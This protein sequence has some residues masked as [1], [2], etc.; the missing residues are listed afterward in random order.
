MEIKDVFNNKK[1]LIWGYGRE[2]KSSE[3]FIRTHCDVRALH[4][5]EGDISGI[6]EDEW[7]IILK[8]PGI[9]MLE[10]RPKYTSQTRLFLNRYGHQTVGITG[11]KGKSTTSSLMYEAIKAC[12]RDAI[13]LG[14]IGKPC[15]DYIDDIKCDTIVV[16]ELSAHQL[17]HIEEAPAVAIFLNLYP[18]HLDYYGTVDK[19]FEAKAN[20]TTHQKSGDT[21]LLGGNVPEISTLADK[22]IIERPDD[23]RREIDL[24][25]PG[26]HNR[27]NAE[28]V[29]RAAVDV[30]G[31][32]EDDVIRG[33]EGF[34]GLPHRLEAVGEYDGVKYFD[35]SIS[36]IPEAAINAV[37]SLGNVRTILIGGMDRGIDYAPLEEFIASNPDINFILMYETGKRIYE[38]LEKVPASGRQSDSNVAN[39]FCVKDL[40]DAVA[41]AK[42]L[43]IP[44][45]STVLSPAAASYGYFKNFEERGDRFKELVRGKIS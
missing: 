34:S 13:L 36:T 6:D 7:D 4:V 20:I 23:T 25:I 10:D 16:F 21:V 38:E 12:G 2:G 31:L 39:V 26:E 18:E 19:Y 22:L 11:T 24:G 40:S 37:R 42:T 29:R 33:M 15:F 17:C 35:D 44:G 43:G 32:P 1:V 45:T 8:S 30:L 9:V 3:E 41:L 28:F 14:N 5:Y 27:L